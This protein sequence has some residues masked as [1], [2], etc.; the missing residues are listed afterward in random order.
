MGDLPR[1]RQ[2]MKNRRFKERSDAG[3]RQNEIDAEGERISKLGIQSAQ[4]PDLGR[5]GIQG[6]SAQGR[7][8]MTISVV[9][10]H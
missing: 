4:W 5:S 3:G 9:F 6:E 2:R 1:V 7:S 8:H 10:V